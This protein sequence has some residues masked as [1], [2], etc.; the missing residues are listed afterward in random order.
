MPQWF[1]NKKAKNTDD[2]WMMKL[3]SNTDIQLFDSFWRSR[4][5]ALDAEKKQQEGLITNCHCEL[6]NRFLWMAVHHRRCRLCL[7]FWSERIKRHR[8]GEER[9]QTSFIEFSGGWRWRRKI[10]PYVGNARFTNIGHLRKAE[11][12]NQNTSPTLD[13]HSR[14]LSGWCRRTAMQL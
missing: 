4:N 1:I 7:Q 2:L 9:W 8:W 3:S 10:L 12:K 5:R 13:R 6:V 14:R 11:E